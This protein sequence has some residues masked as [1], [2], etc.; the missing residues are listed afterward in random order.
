MSTAMGTPRYI[1][2]DCL[3]YHERIRKT[4]IGKL[5]KQAAELGFEVI[6]MSQAAQGLLGRVVTADN[7]DGRR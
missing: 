1:E 2:M 7:A 4:R 5:R 3:L 6:K